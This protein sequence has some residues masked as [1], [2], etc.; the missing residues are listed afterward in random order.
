MNISRN[1]IQGL[2]G[3]LLGGSLLG[4]VEAVYLLAANGAPD[5]LSP[6]YAVVLYGLLGLGLGLGGAVA[7]TVFEK[8]GLFKKADEALAFQFG[9]AGAVA[10]MLLF[11][12]MY[13]GNKVVYGEQG[14]PMTGKLAILGIV[15][16]TVAL[17]LTLG[18]GLLQG[19]LSKLRKAPG[20]LGTWGVLAAVT[21][22]MSFIPVGENPR[23]NLASGKPIPAS[24]KEKPN[25]L[26]FTV[27]TLRA[28][29]L[30]TYGH[31]GNPSPVID[32]IAADGLVFENFFA[33]ASWTRSSFASL[34][35]SRIPSSHN[36]DTKA[37]R[38]PDELELLSEV[39]QGA[40][41]TTGN[42]ANNINVTS[43]FNFD[44]GWDTYIYESPDYSFGATESVFGLTFYKVVHKVNERLGGAKHVSSF[45][46][47]VE[48]LLEDAQAFINANSSA[49]WMLGVHLME[50]HDPYFEHPYLDGTGSKEFNGVGFARA[51]VESPE[52][53]QSEYLKRVY[54]DE[55]RHMDL[56]MA[57]FIEWLKTEGLYDN[58]LI[59][60]TADHG[61]EFGEHGGFWHGTT[62]YE[63]QIHIPLILKL[64]KNELAGTRVQWQ[65][66][67]IDVAPTLTAA[68]GI[69]P[70][71]QWEG[72]DL[73]ADVN[74]EL[75]AR[76]EKAESIAKLRE[77]VALLQQDASAESEEAQ[78]KLAEDRQQLAE[79]EAAPEGCDTYGSPW[80]RVL[81]AEE[82]FEGN[83]ISAIRKDGYKFIKANEGNNRGLPQSEL[84]DM[85]VDAGETENL[86]SS[87]AQRCGAYLTD[88]V[89][90][91][92]QAM[93]ELIMQ[94]SSRAT[95]GGEAE[96][97]AA[98][99]QR[100]C[101]LGYLSGEDCQ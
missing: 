57:P 45:Y 39:M 62:L 32:A 58:T 15:A 17:L 79:L 22:L 80:D 29:Y 40:G 5:L 10:P 89:T 67:S 31:E 6:F 38:M 83:V 68:M 2:A 51:E 84:F 44:Q 87:D 1:I 76:R 54:L 33:S 59:V 42:F 4:L 48:V 37:A 98:E 13:L 41:V 30:G 28:D 78:T 53:S 21:G 92:D 101:A 75:D 52:L 43:T 100:L 61:E 46:Q 81:V 8:F 93:G 85:V 77:S 14:V 72:S 65:S 88:Q 94:A 35:S 47:P 7:L 56:K 26:I 95:S 55:I 20:L 19:P 86:A 69:E 63:E 16:F 27:D 50:P 97:S 96:I 74:A 36:T 12:L 11:I 73:L 64:P 18:R 34:W 71:E 3:G 90:T 49:R 70:S 99:K 9:A 91:L 60:I 25:I 23:A 82:D 66:R 24:L